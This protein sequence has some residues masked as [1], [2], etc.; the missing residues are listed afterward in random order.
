[1]QSQNGNTKLLTYGCMKI[2]QLAVRQLS[3]RTLEYIYSERLVI[4]KLNQSYYWI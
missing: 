2:R 3:F 1:M 4:H